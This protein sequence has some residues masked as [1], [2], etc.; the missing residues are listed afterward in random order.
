MKKLKKLLSGALAFAMAL[1]SLAFVQAEDTT[2]TPTYT[3][4]FADYYYSWKD[5]YNGRE[6]TE[7][8]FMC[9]TDEKAKSGTHSMLIYDNVVNPG[10]YLSFYQSGLATPAGDYTFSI[11]LAGTCNSWRVKIWLTDIGWINLSEW[12]KGETVGEWTNY[13]YNITLTSVKTNREL[14]IA[15]EGYT[16]GET[17]VGTYVDDVSFKDANGNELLVNGSFEEDGKLHWT[18]EHVAYEYGWTENYDKGTRTDDVFMCVTD[19]KA[20]TGTHSMLFV[21]PIST[22]EAE[23]INISQKGLSAASGEYTL[24][25]WVSGDKF[26]NWRTM[27]S[28]SGGKH[29]QCSLNQSETAEH[30]IKTETDGEWSKYTYTFVVPEGYTNTTL[31]F[32][33]EGNTT[34]IYVDDISLT[35]ANGNEFIMNGSFDYKGPEYSAEYDK[36][37]SGWTYDYN[38]AEQSEDVF[39]C[40]TDDM[41]KSGT[42]SMLIYNNVP[43]DNAKATR[44]IQKGLNATAGE[45]TLSFWIAGDYSGWRSMVLFDGGSRMQLGVEDCAKGASV[46][47]WTNYT[48]TFTVAEGTTNTALYLMRQGVST[49]VF[50]DDISLKDEDGNEL[51]ENGGFEE[52]GTVEYT[53]AHEEYLNGWSITYDDATQSD[54]VF[55]C[56]TD[57]KANSGN[58]SVL[59]RNT[60]PNKDGAAAIGISQTGFL[61]PA[62]DYTFSFWVSGEYSGWKTIF[63]LN[64]EKHVG[65]NMDQCTAVATA[66]RWTKYEYTFTVPEGYTN[67]TINFIREGDSKAMYVDNLSLTDANGNELL[68]NGGF[69]IKGD[70]DAVINPVAYPTSEGNAVTLTWKNPAKAYDEIKVYF[71]GDVIADSSDETNPIAVLTEA[72]GFNEIYYSGIEN[73]TEHVAKI[74]A[75]RNGAVVS[76]VE[77]PVWTDDLGATVNYAGNQPLGA[78][79]YLKN[80]NTEDGYYANTVAAIDYEEKAEGNSSIKLTGNMEATKH[81]RYPS[82]QQT[83]TLDHGTMYVLQFKA[84]L[85]NVGSLFVIFNTNDLGEA[86][87]RGTEKLVSSFTTQD[88]KT[89]TVPLVFENENGDS[90]FNSFYAGEMYNGTIQIAVE[91]MVGSIN[92][93]DVKIYSVDESDSTYTPIDPSENLI[94]NGGFEFGTYTVEDAKFEL[95]EETKTTKI[96]TIQSGN[97][98]VTTGIRNIS[99]GDEFKA[100]T[101][102]AVYNNGKLVSCSNIKEGTYDESSVYLPSDKYSTTVTIPEMTATDKYEIK[103]MYWGGLSTMNPLDT[104][105]CLN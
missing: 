99:M 89:Y 16:E 23:A 86:A 79:D 32:Y 48:Y 61:A 3:E 27:I 104:A 103:V 59:I 82:M 35:D 41:A 28:L 29:L 1:T 55:V 85:N 37:S 36:Y 100:A 40:V 50:F 98:K 7:N 76:S 30:A 56:V 42:R 39:M 34:G 96:D 4:E 62:G 26:E 92:I 49:G 70:L 64:G 5:Y 20:K 71:D 73:Y 14:Y 12:E 52:D 88:W 66:G 68:V 9:V 87:I 10:K 18:D 81:L 83:V 51:I 60:V 13:T 8:T 6:Q 90:T 54:D 101:V 105:D 93:D 72:N 43:S 91:K 2:T 11:W 15:G 97:I 102:I 17:Y 33:R 31:T 58:H 53:T 45:Y 46:G 75:L 94:V 22:N 57:D 69:E 38:G 80:E 47:R 21:N 19:E 84:K 24:S 67:N 74:E 78:W 65:G 77:L 44:I 95:V 63:A 25:F